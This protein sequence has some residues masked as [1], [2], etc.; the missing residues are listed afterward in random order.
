MV[1][2]IGFKK[3]EKEDKTYVFI[4]LQ[5]ELKLLQS[6]ETGKFYLTANKTHI[7][8]SFPAEICQNLIGKQLPGNVEREECE[9]YQYVNK[10]TGEVVTVTH[11]CIYTTEANE[12]S[13]NFPMFNQPFTPASTALSDIIVRS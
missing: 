12:N 11:R 9:P 1:T 7:L 6:Q 3:V 4:E 2:I 8:S 13:D 10:E 5:G